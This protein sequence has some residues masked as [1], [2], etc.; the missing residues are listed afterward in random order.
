[1]YINIKITPKR[2]KIAMKITI[3]ILTLL[4]VSMPI[5]ASNSS[6]CGVAMATIDDIVIKANTA[7]KYSDIDQISDVANAIKEDADKALQATDSC[8]CDDAYYTA[9]VIFENANDAYLSDTVEEATGYIKT[10]QQDVVIAK[11]HVKAC[12]IQLAKQ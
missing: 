11:Q 9:E 12:S 3:I 1:M 8:D 7:L 10:V 4:L 5:F 2:G 6:N